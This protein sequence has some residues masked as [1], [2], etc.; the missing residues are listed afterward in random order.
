MPNQIPDRA[1]ASY[2]HVNRSSRTSRSFT[3]HTSGQSEPR[4]ARSTIV[5][6][7]AGR[8][9]ASNKEQ[10]AVIR[11]PPNKAQ[12]AELLQSPK[13]SVRAAM[14]KK[15]P[16]SNSE[17]RLLTISVSSQRAQ[18][19]KPTV[20]NELAVLAP[21]PD[22]VKRAFRVNTTQMH[23][24]RHHHVDHPNEKA[25]RRQQISRLSPASRVFLE[26]RARKARRKIQANPMRTACHVFQAAPDLDSA[27]CQNKQPDPV[28]RAVP[29]QP[30]P[31]HCSAS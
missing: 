1:N 7:R 23:R 30:I 17:S 18:S 26:T 4:S 8:P 20:A 29:P 13:P 28:Q 6:Q 24:A 10:R 15:H 2:M 11:E 9:K 21:T 16:S 22:P 31:Q 12:R 14:S 25:S 3:D 19:P 5:D 27:P